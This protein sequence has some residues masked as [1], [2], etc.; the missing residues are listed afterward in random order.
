MPTPAH[1]SSHPTRRG[2]LG[3]AA[4]AALAGCSSR[5]T[6]S[7][8]TARVLSSSG[9]SRTTFALQGRFASTYLKSTPTY[10]IVLPSKLT[11]IGAAGVV[12]GLHGRGGDHTSI[13]GLHAQAAVDTAYATARRPLALVTVDCGADGYFHRR[14]DGTDAGAMVMQE[15][16]PH[17]AQRGMSTGRVGLYG[18]SMG[19]YGAMLLATRYP[20]MVRAVASA[21][22]AL[23]LSAGQTPA[24]AFDDAADFDRNTIFG[25]I[26]ALERVPLRVDCGDSDPF[27]SATH[28]LRSRLKPPPA[29]GFAPGSHNGSF[30][31]AHLPAAL[32][33]LAQ[34]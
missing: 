11:S 15:L 27:A 29:G 8:P 31:A 28:T 34:H 22:P 7:A 25:R 19:G 20:S 24:G 1:V 26:P 3:G 5:A 18:L 10:Q 6:V 16:L 14:T 13:V 17:L 32:T 33:F 2:L 9:T 30:W 21:S 23:W 4:V 12:I